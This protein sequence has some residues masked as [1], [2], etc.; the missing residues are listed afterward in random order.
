MKPG[1]E[2]VAEKARAD[3]KFCFTSLAHHIDTEWLE[4]GMA[5]VWKH[6]LES[7]PKL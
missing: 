5:S 1:I 6:N 4:I 7:L 3:K 2:R